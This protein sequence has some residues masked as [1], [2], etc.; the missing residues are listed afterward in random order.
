MGF[1]GF[2]ALASHPFITLR[3]GFRNFFTT[4]GTEGT[5]LRQG[6]GGQAE[7]ELEEL[8]S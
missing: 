8:D 7:K 6:F 3:L 2:L 1:S 4:E 5:R